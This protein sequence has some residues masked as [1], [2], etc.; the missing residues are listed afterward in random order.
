MLQAIALLAQ[1]LDLVLAA[2]ELGV[3][4]M[5]AVEAAGIDLDRRRAAACAG[6]LDSLTRG[7]MHLEEIVAVD[8]DRGQAEPGR[9]AGDVAAADRVAKAGALAVL[10]VLED[11]KGRQ[12]PHQRK[13]NA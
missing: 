5:M 7:F 4:R 9:A 12:L 10:V 6:A 8:L 2:V 1:L 11:L 3:A 13:F